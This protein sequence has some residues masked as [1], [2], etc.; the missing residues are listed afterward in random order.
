MKDVKRNL[1]KIIHLTIHMMV[2]IIL[3]LMFKMNLELI[4]IIRTSYIKLINN[5]INSNNEE[6]NCNLSVQVDEGITY[7][8]LEADVSSDINIVID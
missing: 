7:N 5:K 4:K 3:F 1:V 8:K 6:V 2:I